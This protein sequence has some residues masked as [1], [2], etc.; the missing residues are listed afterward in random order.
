MKAIVF[1]KYGPSDVLQL[2]EVE[3]P[4]PKEN[5]VLIR[6]YSVAVKTEDPLN[7]KGKPFIGR[8]TTGLIRPKNPILGA[9]FAGEIEAVGKDV[10]L[11]KGGD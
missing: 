3:K 1:A 6:I 10:K 2:G 11:F 7:R 8:L 5:E 9:D 4:I